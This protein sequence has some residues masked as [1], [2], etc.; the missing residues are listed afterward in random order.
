MFFTYFRNDS[1]LFF[2]FQFCSTR[3]NDIKSTSISVFVDISIIKNQIIIF[4]KSDWTI[5]KSI[6]NIFFI[7]CL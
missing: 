4:D 1:K 6:K 5:F 3:T 7:C 2:C